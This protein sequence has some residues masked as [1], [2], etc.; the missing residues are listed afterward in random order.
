[1]KKILV[2]L[3]AVVAV[4]SPVKATPTME[5]LFNAVKAT[6][7]QILVNGEGCKNP[8]LMGMY[9]YQRNVMDALLL[10][11]DN[12]KGDNAELYDTILHEAVHVA[13]AC[14]QGRPLFTVASL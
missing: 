2:A 10:C 11:V 1:M 7:T 8:Q 13:Q 5:A 4:A 9:M 6:G 14:N 12:H 3:A